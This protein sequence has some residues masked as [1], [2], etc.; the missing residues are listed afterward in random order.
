MEMIKAIAKKIISPSILTNYTSFMSGI[1]S[2]LTTDFSKETIADLVKMQLS[3]GAEWNIISYNVS[4]TGD[5][6]T[7]YSMGNTAA[8]VMIPDMSPVDTAKEL[9]RQLYAGETLVP[10]Q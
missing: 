2:F 6:L 7:T 10:V 9:L 1:S 5:H 3:D 8:Y 4:G